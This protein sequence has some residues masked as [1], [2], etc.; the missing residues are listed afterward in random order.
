MNKIISANKTKGSLLITND[1]VIFR[2]YN[3]DKSF[4]DYNIFHNDLQIVIEDF[5]AY[6]YSDGENNILD[7]SPETLGIKK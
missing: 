1:E 7:H 6:F 4:I 5:D 3:K 2:V